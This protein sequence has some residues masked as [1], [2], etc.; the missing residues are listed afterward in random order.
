MDI[1]IEE[2]KQGNGCKVW[3][4]NTAVSFPSRQEATDYLEQ[5]QERISVAAH[6]FTQQPDSDAIV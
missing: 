4:G 5:L 6:A 3:L 2:E 1:R